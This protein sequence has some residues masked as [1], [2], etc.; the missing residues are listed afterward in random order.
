MS[1]RKRRPTQPGRASPVITQAAKPQVLAVA[2]AQE[3]GVATLARRMIPIAL[4]GAGL[5]A[6]AN[7]FAGAFLLDDLR[8]IVDN[9]QIRH[10]WPPWQV[11]AGTSRPLVEL[12]LALNYALGGL[13]VWGYHAVNLAVHISAALTLYGLVR[14]TLLLESYR[15]RYAHVATPIA[16]IAALLWLVHPV[17]TEAVSTVRP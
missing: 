10:L 11:I 1:R 17:Q 8:R 14:R 5:A 13:N 6:Y 4:V 2:V 7:S 16:M 12:S 15:S 3:S 9:P